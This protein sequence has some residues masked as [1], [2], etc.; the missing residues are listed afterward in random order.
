MGIADPHVI[1]TLRTERLLL[2]AMTLED[3]PVIAAM[4]MDP[5][6]MVYYGNGTPLDE[7]SARE[8]VTKYHIACR[9]HNY[10]AWAVTRLMTGEV[11]GQVTAGYS[12]IDGPQSIELGFILKTTAWG[13]GFGPEAVKAVIEHGRS[14]LA[15][16]KIAAG[17]SSCNL[18]SIRLCNK[19]GM[20]QIRSVPS[21]Q[22]DIR[23]IFVA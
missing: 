19:V 1:H 9:D 20:V 10:W 21:R 11:L 14:M 15:W 2:R 8:T 6:V 12:D 13:F 22:G 5:E 23:I 16:S 17:V 4:Q 7:V 3:T 18:R